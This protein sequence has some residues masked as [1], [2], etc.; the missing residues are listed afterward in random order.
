MADWF[1]DQGVTAPGEMVGREPVPGGQPGAGGGV[2]PYSDSA[3]QEILHRYPP[4]NAGV[5]QAYAEAQRVFGPNAPRLLDHPERLDKFVL[6]DGR[7]I[8]AVMGSGGANPSWGWLVEGTGHGGGGG[9]GGAVG[10]LAGMTGQ[11]PSYDFRFKEGQK[12]LER[13]AASK[14]TLLTG[15]TLKDLAAFGQ[16]LAST[17]FG[18][19]F[20]RNYQLANMGLNAA[21]SAGQFGSSYG[22]N[23]GNQGANFAGNQSNLLTGQGNANAAGTIGQ[24]GA[25]GNTINQLA[26]GVASLP[27][28]Q[29]DRGN[30]DSPVSWPNSPYADSRSG[31]Y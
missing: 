11:D 4:T 9:G 20:N 12:A 29:R 18:N 21:Q 7:T 8:D 5:Q 14:G 24:A 16:G 17:E 15:G 23:A 6:P 19:I 25:W 1:D 28:F 3:F 30:Y 26:G 31:R 10:N 13:S 2:Q 22:A 27:W